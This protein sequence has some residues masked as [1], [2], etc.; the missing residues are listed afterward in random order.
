[1][2]IEKLISEMTLEEKASL[3][4]G[5]DFWHTKAVERL[6]IP[7]TMLSDGPHG[8]RKQ[9]QGGDHLGVNDSIKAVCFPAASA[10]AA[11][12]DRE[13][14]RKIGEGI[15]DACQHED[16]SVILGPAVNIKRSPVCGRNFEY[17]SEDPYLAGEL[18]AA[19]IQGVQSRNIGTC[20]KHFAANSQEH[21]RMSSDSVVDERTL[22]EIYFPAFETAVKKAKPWTVMCS[23]NKLNGEFASQHH[24]LLT[25]VLRNEWGFDGYVVSDWGAVSDRVK[26]V[27]AGL[28]LEMPGSGG[29]ND[30]R[31][32]N[33][34]KDGRL[35]EKDVDESVRRILAIIDRYESNRRPDT[36]WDMEAQ[37]VLARELAAE[38]MVLLKN[39]DGILPISS[40]EKVAVIGKFAAAPRYQGGGSSHI[41]S[42][43]VESLLDALDGNENIIYAQ[44]Y[45]TVNEEPDEVLITQAVAAA[46]KA[47]KAVI[48]AGLPD[49]FESEGY[50][51][52]HMRMPNCQNELIRRVAQAN[53]NTIVILY[54]GSP[55]EM[56]WINEVKGVI[57]AY[58]GGQ[59]VGGAT[60]AV[61]WGDVN[62]S[63]R[64]PETFPV[65][66]EDNPSYLTYG[67]E[68]NTA[69]YSEGVFVGY[70]YYDKKKVNVLFPFGYGLSY[71][72]FTYS[73]LT[74]S[75]PSIKDTDALTVTVDVTNTGEIAG[76]EV[77]Q[78]YVQPPVCEVFRPVRELKGVEKIS[79]APGETKSVSFTLEKRAFAYWNKDLHDWFVP[80]GVYTIEIGRSSRDIEL[81]KAVEVTGTVSAPTEPLTVNTIFMDLQKNPKAMEA[82]QPLFGKATGNIGSSE[83]EA[84]LEENASEESAAAK[85]A[86]SEEMGDAMMRYMPLRGIVSFSGGFV[87]YDQ[88]QEI[89]DKLNQE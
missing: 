19:L 2:D 27:A 17:F 3:L 29:T 22:R 75:A 83:E 31:I 57:E 33:A 54:N 61:L 77:I 71:T 7:R 84:R 68:G 4:S 35:D 46:A 62:P 50:D 5:D 12:F 86:I 23:Y 78:L 41:N 76:K 45:D 63:G 11:S 18:A 8:L 6:G 13:V 1:M 64:L 43:K 32:V 14:L 40:A 34:V 52:T 16:L 26:G 79:L 80:T 20:I 44:G 69:V 10:T 51:R 88:L 74:I 72:D 55:I 89:I 73:N 24:W 30:V 59:A 66:L 47:D 67:G 42:F 70:R 9:D 38:C 81:T 48:V 85:E 25:E 28:D 87:S 49:S 37:H 15:G 36:P 60:K 65:H 21:R 82:L 53:P 58:L 39:E 56:P